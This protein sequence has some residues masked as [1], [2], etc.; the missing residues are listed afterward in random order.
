MV[1]RAPPSSSCGGL[2]ALQAPNAKKVCI[3]CP[4]GSDMCLIIR[5]PVGGPVRYFGSVEAL[6]TSILVDV[7]VCVD[8]RE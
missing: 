1:L 7:W 8:V 5:Y 4:R 3:G 6:S 2:G